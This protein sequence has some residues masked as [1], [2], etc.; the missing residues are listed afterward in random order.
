MR[1][2]PAGLPSPGVALR[3]PVSALL[4]VAALFA[5]VALAVPWAA[6]PSF[7]SP[8]TTTLVNEFNPSTG[9][10]DLTS[11]YFPGFY[12]PGSVTFG[13]QSPVRIVLVPAIA[14]LVWASRRRTARDWRLARWSAWALAGCSLYGVG[15]HR[16]VPVAVTALAAAL[17]GYAARSASTLGVNSVRAA[18]AH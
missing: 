10:L 1:P 14:V 2:G 9:D 3:A 17:A 13:R 7:L 11:Q 5:A 8:G 12:S 6:T 4:V 15:H 18:P 16:V